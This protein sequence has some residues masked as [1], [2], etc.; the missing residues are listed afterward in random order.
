MLK[1][2]QWDV[3]YFLIKNGRKKKVKNW[4][5]KV[6]AAYIK[7]YTK[8]FTSIN[9]ENVQSD[10]PVRSAGNWGRS[11]HFRIFVKFQKSKC[12]LEMQ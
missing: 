1:F 8:T 5:L 11:R 12:N 9:K 2:L 7:H 10:C 3:L 4:D 6:L